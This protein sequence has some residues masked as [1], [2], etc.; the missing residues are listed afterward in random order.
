MRWAL[1][2]LREDV[3]HSDCSPWSSRASSQDPSSPRPQAEEEERLKTMMTKKHKR[4]LLRINQRQATKDDKV[5]KAS[6]AR[7]GIAALSHG[8]RWLSAGDSSGMV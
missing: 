2:F 5:R 8:L 3:D 4:M 1:R 6:G 7:G